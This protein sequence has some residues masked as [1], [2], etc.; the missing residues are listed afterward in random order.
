MMDDNKIIE[1]YWT[2][3]ERALEATRTK[4]GHYCYTIAYNI[5]HNRE[6]SD[7]CVND[8]YLGAW[9][10]IPP[11]RPQ[12]LSTFLGKITRNLSLKQL[13]T[14][15]AQKRGGG[16]AALA[17]EELE[18]CIPSQSST[19]EAILEEELTKTLDI[20]LRTLPE[21]ERRIF[22][23]RYWYFD[24]ISAI[25]IRYGFGKSKVKMIL[26][27]TREKLRHYLEQ[28]DIYL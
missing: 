11:H 1:L 12:L 17:L 6:D 19:E 3:D 22:L 25:C 14:R 24:S 8:T 2:R 28:E 26:L 4:Y 10:S 7:E 23:C 9:N 27:R 13:R 20:F 15:S 21:T 5:L 18:E 16:E